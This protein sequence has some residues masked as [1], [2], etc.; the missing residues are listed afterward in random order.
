VNEG[1][2]LA[3][4]TPNARP[5][6]SARLAQKGAAAACC[7]HGTALAAPKSIEHAGRSRSPLSFPAPTPRLGVAAHFYLYSP[8]NP[9]TPTT[10][11]N[12]PPPGLTSRYTMPF[13]WHCAMK[14]SID[15]TSPDM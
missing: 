9:Q 1:G 3:L 13:A 12:K 10:N 5:A 4:T 7:P 2:R 8:P 14:R 6:R 15:R 11:P